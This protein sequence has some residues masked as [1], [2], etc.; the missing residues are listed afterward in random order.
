MFINKAALAFYLAAAIVSTTELACNTNLA[1]TT[2][3]IASASASSFEA[4]T[5]ACITINPCGPDKVIDGYTDTHWVS[6][7]PVGN[8]TVWFQI[9]FHDMVYIDELVLTLTWDEAYATEY[10]VLVLSDETNWILVSTNT[11]GSGG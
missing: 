7:R 1:C 8:N 9:F 3:A 4:G 6:P 10:E 5:Q 2:V 11:N